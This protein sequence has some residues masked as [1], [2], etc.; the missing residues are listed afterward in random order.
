M[1]KV[2]IANRG[3]IAVRVIRACHDMGLSTVAV[4]SEAD[5]ESLH[6]L[7][8]DEAVCIGPPPSSE[9]Y[10]KISRILSAC[11]MTGADAI[12]PGYGFLSENAKF[13][14]LCKTCDIEFIGPSSETIALLGDKAK[15]KEIAKRAKCPVIPGSLG[16]VKDL[17]EGLKE[18][19]II[20]YPIFIKATAGGGG[21]GIR[22]AHD[23]EEFIRLFPQARNEAEK[24]F[25]NPDVYLE[26]MI[27]NPRHIEVQ[28][29]ADK[30]GHCIHLGERDCTVQ[31]R[32]QKLI[33]ECPSPALTEALRREIGESAVRIAKEAGYSTVGTVEFLLDESGHFYFMEVNTRIQ[34][35]H[36]ITEEL[37]DIDLVYEQIRMAMG[38]KLTLQQE[39]VIFADHIMQFRINAENPHAHFTPSPGNLEYFIPSGG[40]HVRVDTHCYPGYTIP[41]YYDSMIAKLIVRGKTREETINRAKRAL[42]EFHVGGIHTTIPF[43][44]YMLEHPQFLANHYSINFIDN[45]IKEGCEFKT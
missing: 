8:A 13:A 45:L 29:I 22:V 44:L 9:S 10:L 3:E 18:A 5:K 19:Q 25:G 40:P 28:I 31:R 43:H 21:K 26:K 32:R 6:V 33:E 20:G 14:S 24:A 11:E 34:V 4:Y 36:T 41:P 2:L 39:D 7:H 17:E 23:K 16:I 1:K 38:E 12:H 27:V 42:K 15:A 30:F 35:E 37:T